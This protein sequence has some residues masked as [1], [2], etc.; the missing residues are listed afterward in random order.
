M[1][2]VIFHIWKKTWWDLGYDVRSCCKMYRLLC[3]CYISQQNYN[4]SISRNARA[5]RIT[6]YDCDKHHSSFL[7][8]MGRNCTLFHWVKK[9]LPFV[10]WIDRVTFQE[11]IQPYVRTKFQSPW[12]LKWLLFGAQAHEVAYE[13]VAVSYSHISSSSSRNHNSNFVSRG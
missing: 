11:W 7:V 12:Q 1:R 4:F 13:A 6:R 8:Y 3:S 5:S 2:F 10:V 9:L